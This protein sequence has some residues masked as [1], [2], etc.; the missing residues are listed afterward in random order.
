MHDLLDSVGDAHRALIEQIL[1]ENGTADKSTVSG[2]RALDLASPDELVFCKTETPEMVAAVI[3]TRSRFIVARPQLLPLLPSQ[4]KRSRVLVL[5]RNPRAL[6]AALAT[7]LETR[8]TEWRTRESLR[9]EGWIAADALIAPGVVFGPGVTIGRRCIVGPNSVLAHVTIGD[10]SRI[11]SNCSIGGDGFGFEVDSETGAVTKFP[12]FGRV[13][14]G[15]N[16]EIFSNVCIARG[17]LRDT[18]IE[19]HVK[20]DNLVHVAHNCTIRRGAFLIAN[21]MIGGSTII[22][23]G[24]WIAP[25]TSVLNGIVVGDR[26]MTGMGAVVT[27]AVGTNEIVAGVPARKLRDRFPNPDPGSGGKQ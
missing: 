22:G 11:G 9:G 16:V 21:S 6:I 14:I 5:T 10:D 27:K 8:S 15:K 7:P 25:S 4:F 2:A 17:S 20:I 3:A 23:E 24:A 12:H 19:D 26:A 1:D 13:T 18:V